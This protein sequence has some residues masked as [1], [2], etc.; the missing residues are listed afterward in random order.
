[1]GAAVGLF[2]GLDLPPWLAKMA[3]QWGPGFAMVLGIFAGIAY[4]VP[5]T[6]VKQFADAQTAQALALHDIS[7]SMQ[8]MSGQSGKLEGKIDRLLQQHEEILLDLRVGSERFKRL[9]EGLFSERG[10]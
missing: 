8:E 2:S 10:H 3:E 9:E 1:M 4:Y 7:R 6:F 5:R